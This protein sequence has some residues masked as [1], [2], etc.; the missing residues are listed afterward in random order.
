MNNSEYN[1]E[2]NSDNDTWRII[3]GNINSF[4]TGTNGINQYKLDKLQTLLNKKGIDIALI[5]E[6]N[7]NVQKLSFKD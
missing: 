6:H 4:P 5:S 2:N 1:T 7:R 3:I